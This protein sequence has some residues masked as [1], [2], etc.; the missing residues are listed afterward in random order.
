M[1]IDDTLR[2]VEVALF[3][4]PASIVIKC[5]NAVEAVLS[6]EADSLDRSYPI[7]ENWRVETSQHLGCDQT[8]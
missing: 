2:E 7:Q 1:K 6:V 5:I 3:G 4:H 8:G